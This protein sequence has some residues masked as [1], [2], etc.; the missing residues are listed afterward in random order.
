MIHHYL[1]RYELKETTVREQVRATADGAMDKTMP[2][3]DLI[4]CP[5]YDVAYKDDA[6]K[7]FGITKSNYRK[8]KQFKPTTNTSVDLDLWEV[9]DSVTYNVHELLSKVKI[10]TEDA[11]R[12]DYVENFNNHKNE[13]EHFNITTKYQ[14]NL[15][16]CFSIIPYSHVVKQGVTLIDFTARTSIYVY[17]SYP[18]QF[19]YDTPTKVS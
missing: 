14:I 18:G 6:L 17:M 5:R 19:V 1:K 16:K 15:G 9:F 12:R 7:R 8:A 3:L 10:K 2:F 11:K 13:S 4:V